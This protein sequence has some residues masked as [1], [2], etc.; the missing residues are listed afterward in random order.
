MADLKT[1]G[2]PFLIFFLGGGVLTLDTRAYMRIC[3]AYS[4]IEP[5]DDI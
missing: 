1:L 3:T 2:P 4:T 5:I